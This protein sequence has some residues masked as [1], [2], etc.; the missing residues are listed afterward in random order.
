MNN[1]EIIKYLNYN[2]KMLYFPAPSE[3]LAKLFHFF[4]QI[5]KLSR[6]FEKNL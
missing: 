5:S 3:A 4:L 6:K 1:I 2:I